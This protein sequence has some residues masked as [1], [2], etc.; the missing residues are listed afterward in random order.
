MSFYEGNFQ[1]LIM[2]VSGSVMHPRSR[3]SLSTSNPAADGEAKG[4]LM[5]W[6]HKRNQ[7]PWLPAKYVGLP[8]KC[9]TKKH[10]RFKNSCNFHNHS[11]L[12]YYPLTSL[13]CLYSWNSWIM[14]SIPFI[15][16]RFLRWTLEKVPLELPGS[17]F[18]I[19]RNQCPCALCQVPA[20][21]ISTPSPMS[22]WS[23]PLQSKDRRIWYI[24]GKRKWV[25][26][27]SQKSLVHDG[28]F[29]RRACWLATAYL[30]HQRH[31]V[32]E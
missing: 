17:A 1:K 7:Q 9:G 29:L 8:A 15:L 30:S 16:P 2:S 10:M 27:A 19:S 13:M 5:L 28:A 20:V 4:G 3:S 11:S 23:T 14:S 6:G 21:K 31:P 18:Q 25:K 12:L 24:L 26:K 32:I 22:R